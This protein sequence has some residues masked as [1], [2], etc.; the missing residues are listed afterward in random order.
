MRADRGPV[1]T[2]YLLTHQNQLRH[3][4]VRDWKQ[5]QKKTSRGYAHSKDKGKSFDISSG[6]G[7]LSARRFPHTRSPSTT[8]H[9]SAMSGGARSGATALQGL[10]L[11]RPHSLEVSNRMQQAAADAAVRPPETPPLLKV[12][13]QRPDLFANDQSLEQDNSEK[14][15][16]IG[17]IK[18]RPSVGYGMPF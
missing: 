17:E 15:L 7:P 13:T 10:P 9:A 18:V 4:S 6:G 8:A 1:P 5:T 2:P 12:T 11:V 3:I 16:R 14:D